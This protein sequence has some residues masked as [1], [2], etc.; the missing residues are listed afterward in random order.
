MYKKMSSSKVKIGSVF[1]LMI[2]IFTLINPVVFAKEL[3]ND[4]VIDNISL[5]NSEIYMNGKTKI[6]VTFSEKPD[7]KILGGDTITLDLPPELVGYEGT[8]KLSEFGEAVIKSNKIIVTFNENASNKEH[9][10]GDFTFT[11][12]SISQVENDS[13]IQVPMDLG[14]GL[15]VPY[16]TIKGYPSSSGDDGDREPTPFSYKGGES[17]TANPELIKWYIVVNPNSLSVSDQV[18]LSDTLGV[19]QN[20]LRDSFEINGL[21]ISEFENANYGKVNFSEDNFTLTINKEY[22]DKKS[23][24][25][26][27][28]TKINDQGKSLKELENNFVVSYQ[29]EGKEPTSLAGRGTAVNDISQD[30]K[31]EGDDS[32]PNESDTT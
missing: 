31:A 16:L 12:K 30:G 13:Q 20:L 18:I 14:T 9:I 26:T 7:N 28:K 29:E 17:D 23:I 6:T 15:P 22:I 19:G 21:S 27:Y 8:I 5:E 3:K 32:L 11:V 1:L 25:L 10:K 4:N 2:S 24:S